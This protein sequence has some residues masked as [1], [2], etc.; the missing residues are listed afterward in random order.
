MRLTAFLFAGLFASTLVAE[1][2]RIVFDTD[3][4]GDYDDVGA[5]AVLNALADDGECEIIAV[6]SSSRSSP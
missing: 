4:C 3:M 6:L 2:T 1:P 5:L